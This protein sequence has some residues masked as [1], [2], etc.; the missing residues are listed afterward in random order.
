[1]VT[2]SFVL[3]VLILASWL[4]SMAIFLCQSFVTRLALSLDEIAAVR[5]ESILALF[6]GERTQ[7]MLAEPTICASGLNGRH[8]TFQVPVV[9]P[10]T[11]LIIG[12]NQR[13]VSGD[14]TTP[15]YLTLAYD[16]RVL[17]GFTVSRFA[18]DLIE[19]V[20]GGL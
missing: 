18:D 7:D 20:L 16:H 14:Q 10:M 3:R 15:V 8:L 4:M 17:S 13:V 12:I 9:Y 1:M 11:S 2:L 6:R 19:A 5:A